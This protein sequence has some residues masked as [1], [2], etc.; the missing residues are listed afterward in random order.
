MLGMAGT[1]AGAL[2]APDP[3]FRRACSSRGAQPSSRLHQRS[4]RACPQ[5]VY[6]VSRLAGR[7]AVAAGNQAHDA[8][9]S[10][11][12][13]FFVGQYK[14]MDGPLPPVS[15]KDRSRIA[16]TT[17]EQFLADCLWAAKQ[18]AATSSR[19]FGVSWSGH[20]QKWKVE[21]V[22]KHGQVSYF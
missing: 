14:D 1:L 6:G 10:C 4:A 7:P 20:E 12:A 8:S 9:V 15:E 19:F 16:A 21:L 2:G 22:Q 5:Q 17:L 11:R 3:P 13:Y 18:E